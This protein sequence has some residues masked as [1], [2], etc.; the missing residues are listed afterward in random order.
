MPDL[1]A[2]R[3]PHIA[4]ALDGSECLIS[5]MY[6]AKWGED[7]V[8]LSEAFLSDG[9]QLNAAKYRLVSFVEYIGKKDFSATGVIDDGHFVA[10]FR[11]NN[12]WYRANDSAVKV[13]L[14][15]TPI[16]FPYIC[17]LER[18]GV[19]SDESYRPNPIT[20]VSS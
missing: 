5:S 10:Y 8:D 13:F 3:V 17:F 15:C 20:I 7:D 11:E 4:F 6:E 18:S 1:L 19:L 12:V 14:P 9:I 16:P 2:V